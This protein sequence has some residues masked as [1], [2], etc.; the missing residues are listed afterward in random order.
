MHLHKSLFLL[1]SHAFLAILLTP[2]L[3]IP[4]FDRSIY[5]RCR[6]GLPFDCPPEQVC[7]WRIESG[8]R[9]TC[10]PESEQANYP[11]EPFAPVKR[12]PVPAIPEECNKQQCPFGM[13]CKAGCAGGSNL[14]P[15]Q[16]HVA[17][18][19]KKGK[20]PNILRNPVGY[21][22]GKFKGQSSEPKP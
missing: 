6:K 17:P 12:K 14:V 18:A 13:T 19:Q 8:L 5:G 22:R 20:H 3:A 2:I 15:V 4:T 7:V 10:V 9:G 16:P 1:F 21:F 11:W